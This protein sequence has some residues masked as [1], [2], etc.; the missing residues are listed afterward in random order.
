MRLDV[1]TRARVI[2]L[3]EEGY[4]YKRIRERLLEEGTSVSVKSLYLLVAK[5]KRTKS[6]LD[7][8]R[9]AI[10]KILRDEHYREIDKALSENDEMTSR[11]LR[12]MLIRKWPNLSMSISTVERARRELGWVVTTP[13]YCQLIR[14]QN[15]QKRLE[16]CQKMIDAN[17]QFNDVMFT[18]ESSVQ[19]ETH[20]KRCY[21][22]K[23]T[24]RKLKPRPKH[25]LKVHIWGGISKRG[26]TSVV[27]F[28]GIM[29][30]TRYTQIL[31]A[32]LL[33]CADDLYPS[34]FRFQQDND[35]K[36]C[37]NYTQQFFPEN[38]INWWPTP[39]ESPDLNPIENVWGSLKEYLRNVHKP[40]NLEELKG[41][42]KEFWKSLTPEVCTR[43][44]NHLHRVIPAVI[45]K[46][47][48]PSGF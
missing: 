28:T 6:V 31:E 1:Q 26:P 18:D 10:P 34:G 2:R 32:G 35:P 29:T 5:Y 27:I 22:K 19:L 4:T 25:P 15:K 30:A 47:G 43:Y 12:T 8:P 44:I 24:P 13:K 45:E 20:R 21:R 39:P 42:I 36:H 46:Q 38:A 17:E 3:K 33:P 48:S 41:G 14:E 9:A 37:A 11:Q 40:K 16:W 7:R 23:R